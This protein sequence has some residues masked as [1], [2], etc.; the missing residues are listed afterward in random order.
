MIKS[1]V[2]MI[3]IS[4]SI[5]KWWNSIDASCSLLKILF[6][7]G[8]QNSLPIVRSWIWVALAGRKSI[9]VSKSIK[10]FKYKT[11]IGGNGSSLIID[12]HWIEYRHKSSSNDF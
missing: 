11:W 12:Y 9:K 3:K 4:Y 1:C 10:V 6:T 5:E 7:Q 8:D 2:G